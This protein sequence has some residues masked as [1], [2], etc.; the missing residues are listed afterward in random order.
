MDARASSLGLHG[1]S[2]RELWTVSSLCELSGYPAALVV[3]LIIASQ[4]T[5]MQQLRLEKDEFL[6]TKSVRCR[7]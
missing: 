7:V 6:Y 4:R 2:R 1:T 5:A 3:V